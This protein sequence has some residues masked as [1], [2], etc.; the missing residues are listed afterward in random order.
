VNN[1]L[2]RLAFT[3]DGITISYGSDNE[4]PV[5]STV[6]NWSYAFSDGSSLVGH[7]DGQLGKDKKTLLNPTNISA[8]YIDVDGKTVLVSWKDKD[9][10]SFETT[11]DKGNVLI[12][13]SNDNFVANSM[14]LV[15][16]ETRT[17]AQVTEQ[18]VQLVAESL[19]PNT[20]SITPVNSF[21]SAPE[22]G[23][24]LD[25]SFSSLF[26]FFAIS[27]NCWLP[28]PRLMYQWTFL[29]FLPLYPFLRVMRT[30][31]YSDDLVNK[32]GYNSKQPRLA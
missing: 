15:S 10:V 19:K 26:P 11:L 1:Y 31:S 27:L 3:S 12:V 8:D 30:T 28:S 14:C 5:E 23:I 29:P 2:A 18:G 6:F 20:W 32:A 22:S 9:F 24:G 16:S 17:R 4:N 7:V 13:A 21:V 25:W